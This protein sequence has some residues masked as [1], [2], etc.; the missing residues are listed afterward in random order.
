MIWVFQM[1]QGG[2]DQDYRGGSN[3]LVWGSRIQVAELAREKT[4]V[5]AAGRI[6]LYNLSISPLVLATD[7]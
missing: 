7:K 6:R 1:F 5:A 4:A 3:R 2:V